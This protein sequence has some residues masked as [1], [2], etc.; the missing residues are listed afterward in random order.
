MCKY[1]AYF[2]QIHQAQMNIKLL[3]S[4]IKVARKRRGMSLKMLGEKAGVHY[5]QISRME[6]GE[7]VLLSKNLRKVCEILQ[8]P[9]PLASG[10]SSS[11][12]LPQ[13]VQDLINAW[14]QSEQLIRSVVDAL[15][16]ALENGDAS[17]ARP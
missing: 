5:T 13:K 10:A 8:V 7:G 4:Q 16:T 1:I 17:V 14:P 11:G 2:L 15:E 6:R 9:V 12:D 3:G